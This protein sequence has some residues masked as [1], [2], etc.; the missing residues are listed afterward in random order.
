MKEVQHHYVTGNGINFHVVTAGPEDGRPVM[1]LHGFPDFWYG[2]NAQIAVLAE[3]GYRVIAPDL[4]G[5]NLTDK[6]KMVSDYKI[7]VLM[8]DVIA[9]INAFGYDQVLLA[10]HDWGAAVAWWLV[11]H[12]PEYVERVVILNVPYPTFAKVALQRG[13]FIQL[14][15]SWY[16]YFFQ[17]PWLPEFLLRWSGRSMRRNPLVVSSHK[18]TF[19]AD[20][21]ARYQAAWEK[22]GAWTAMLNWYRA[23]L[24]MLALSDYPAEGS[25]LVPTLILWGEQDIAL[26]KRL[27]ELSAKLCASSELVMY[28]EA[29]HWVHHDVTEK[30]NQELLRF[31]R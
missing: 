30:V 22:P 27:A 11:K 2:W 15:K 24:R 9:L 21:L 31:F 23:A 20:D 12:R 17:I 3:A 13:L 7:D 14:L 26:D 29:T 18:D 6:P 8:E 28:P 16:I 10:A 25:I 1:L 4:R 19:S 5:Y